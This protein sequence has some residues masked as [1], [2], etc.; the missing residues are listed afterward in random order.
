MYSCEVCDPQNKLYTITSALLPHSHATVQVHGPAA[1][2]HHLPARHGHL[3][4]IR[5]DWE[6][7]DTCEYDEDDE[8]L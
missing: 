2:S 3:L 7:K 8:L 6:W 4:R 1:S 5:P